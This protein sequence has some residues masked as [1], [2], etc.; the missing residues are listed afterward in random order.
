MKKQTGSA[1]A[2]RRVKTGLPAR[3]LILLLL[4]GIGYQL[5]ALRSQVESA[6]ADRAALA[7]QVETRQQENDALSADIAQG[8][9]SEKMEEIAR[10]ELGLVTPGEYVF[11]DVSN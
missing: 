11:Y 5:Y 9:T 7:A 2:H 1:K 10:D 4:V 8:N 6:Q 3:I